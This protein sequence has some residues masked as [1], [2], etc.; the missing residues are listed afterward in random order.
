MVLK[1]NQIVF[2][3]FCRYIAIL[4]PLRPRMRKR[5]VLVAIVIIWIISIGLSMP[6]L[7]KGGTYPLYHL[8]ICNIMWSYDD[9]IV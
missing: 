3:L 7:V 2:V 1:T 9:H 8:V 4:Y 6:A 5:H